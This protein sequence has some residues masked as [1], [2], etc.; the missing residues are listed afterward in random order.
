MNTLYK[1]DKDNNNNNA[2]NPSPMNSPHNSIMLNGNEIYGTH[3]FFKNGKLNPLSEYNVKIPYR[4]SLD[5][6]LSQE[7]AFYALQMHFNRL[8]YL[9]RAL[10]SGMWCRVC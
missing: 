9:L 10:C 4:H 3:C 5:L 1:G 7:N 2:L 6:V 8:L